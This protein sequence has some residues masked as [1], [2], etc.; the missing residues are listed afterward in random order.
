VGEDGS[1]LAGAS[2]GG[3]E[4]MRPPWPGANTTLVVVGTDA[5]L[6]RDRA[7]LLAVAAHDGVARA[8]RP[9][10][11]IWDGDTVFSLAT[12]VVEAAQPLVER[13]AEGVVAEAIRSA[14]GEG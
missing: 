4:E 14:V 13:M 8:V 6:S 12:G 7:H 11:T 3:E 2:P 1:V 9:A 10:H 5:K